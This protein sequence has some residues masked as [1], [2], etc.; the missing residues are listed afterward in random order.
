MLFTGREIVYFFLVNQMVQSVLKYL[1][2]VELK[3]VKLLLV[4]KNK[5]TSTSTT[6]V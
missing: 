6:K 4:Y 1:I 5:S 2:L 3:E